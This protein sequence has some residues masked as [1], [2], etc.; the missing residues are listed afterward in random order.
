[1]PPPTSYILL[2]LPSRIF[3]SGD[4]Q[5]GLA[6]LS[7]TVSSD[8]G[9]VRAFDVPEFK[10]GTLDALV[11]QAD[12]LAKLDAGCEGVVGRVAD[13]LKAVFDADEAKAAEHKTVNDSELPPACLLSRCCGP[14]L[15]QPP[16]L[17]QSPST[18]ISVPSAGTRSDTARLAPS[19]S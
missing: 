9:A 18:S 12:D 17:P 5:D 3:E 11:Q 7:A 14:G 15:T 6:S 13:S 8:N 16:R 1:M 10:I 19:A 4:R 2:S